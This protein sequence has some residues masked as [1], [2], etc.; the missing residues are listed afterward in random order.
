M[1]VEKRV[2]NVYRQ[3]ALLAEAARPF[4]NIP[5]HLVVSEFAESADW[6]EGQIKKA[7]RV[8]GNRDRAQSRQRGTL[9]SFPVRWIWRTRCRRANWGIAALRYRLLDSVCMGLSANYG[10]SAERQEGIKI[11]RAA[12]ER[13]VTLFDTVEDTVEAGSHRPACDSCFCTT[14]STGTHKLRTRD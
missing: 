7:N 11:I 13:G 9:R 1:M 10:P 5:C 3:H 12:V 2:P 8:R 4:A 6:A 14:F